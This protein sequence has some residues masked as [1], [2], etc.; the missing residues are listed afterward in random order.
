MKL[1]RKSMSKTD[2]SG[3]PMYIRSWRQLWSN[4]LYNRRY[5]KIEWIHL[6]FL[7]PSTNWNISISQRPM[8]RYIRYNGFAIELRR[9]AFIIRSIWCGSY[10]MDSN[11]RSIWYGSY[12]TVLDIRSISYGRNHMVHIIW[13]ISYGPYHMVYMISAWYFQGPLNPNSFEF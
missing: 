10:H 5:R 6:C 2:Q 7:W 8:E 9:K 11:I 3:R 4:W 13:S 12:H 1:G